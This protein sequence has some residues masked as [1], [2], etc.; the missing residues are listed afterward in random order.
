[1]PLILPSENSRSIRKNK[2]VNYFCEHFRNYLYQYI[3]KQK[4]R[5]K[6]SKIRTDWAE[7][8]V[9]VNILRMKG[10]VNGSVAVL[11]ATVYYITLELSISEETIYKKIQY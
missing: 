5:P 9:N 8:Y 7:R 4:D 6:F 11:M 1:M 2:I 10:I 3:H